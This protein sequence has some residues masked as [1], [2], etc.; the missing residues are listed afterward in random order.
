MRKGIQESEHK[1]H[2]SDIDQQQQDTLD[3]GGLLAEDDR[4]HGQQ[5]YQ[6]ADRKVYANALSGYGKSLAGDDG[7]YR[8]NQ[9][10]IDDIGA[11][12]IPNGEAGFLFDDGGDGSH[13]LWQGSANRD[14]GNGDDPLRDAQ[15][16]GDITAVVD[17][18]LAAADNCRRAKEEQDDV[19]CQKL[20]FTG[21]RA[22]VSCG[23]RL[24]DRMFCAMNSAKITANMILP[25]RLREPD[26]QDSSSTVAAAMS[27]RI[28]FKYFFRLQTMGSAIM[29]TAIIRAVFAVTEPTALPMAISVFPSA[30]AIQ[31]TIISGIVV[32][33]LTMVA[34]MINVGIFSARAIQLAAS[35][36]KSPPFTTRAIPKANKKQAK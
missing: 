18:K 19:F 5:R 3:L 28:C 10:E 34:P 16:Y 1:D 32:A 2:V 8:E 6:Q 33:R 22:A 17:H 9:G 27:K 14:Q 15:P 26:R 12:D 30:A 20:F 13:Q 7:A 4:K 25:I 21:A 11:D 31:D 24:A 23:S 36:K 29:A 35:T